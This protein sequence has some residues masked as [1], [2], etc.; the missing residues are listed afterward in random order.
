MLIEM[1][2]IEITFLEIKIMTRLREVILTPRSLILF[3]FFFGLTMIWNENKNT[4]SSVFYYVTRYNLAFI[5]LYIGNAKISVCEM[6]MLLNE[7]VMW[8]FE[9]DVSYIPALEYKLN[10]SFEN[11]RGKKLS[12]AYKLF[13]ITQKKILRPV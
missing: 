5:F 6:E 13:S 4:V 11:L 2:Q 9:W 1:L 3:I 10:I 8:K 7:K 12:V